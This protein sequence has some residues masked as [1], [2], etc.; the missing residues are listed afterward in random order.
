MFG[1]NDRMSSNKIGQIKA[2]LNG[3]DYVFFDEVSM[4]SARDLYRINTQLAKVFGVSDIPFGG[5]NMVFCAI[6]LSSLQPSVVNMSLFTPEQLGP[7]R[8]IAGRSNWESSVAPNNESGDFEAKYE[9]KQAK[10]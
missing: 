2:K 4:L 1:I 7:L 5:L 6:L 10:P 9:T 8:Q 3:V